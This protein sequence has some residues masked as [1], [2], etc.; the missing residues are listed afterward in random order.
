MEKKF[1]DNTRGEREGAKKV[2][3]RQVERRNLYLKKRR[4]TQ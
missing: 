1:S 2:C 4:N 3:Y